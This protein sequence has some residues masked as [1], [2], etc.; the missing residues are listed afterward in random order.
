MWY[1]TPQIWRPWLYLSTREADGRQA[2]TTRTDPCPGTS[3]SSGLG[4]VHSGSLAV[5]KGDTCPLGSWMR[6][7]GKHGQ[8]PLAQGLALSLA[9]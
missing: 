8:G 5:S 2:A 1:S 4:R 6:S 7:S 3:Q 9:L